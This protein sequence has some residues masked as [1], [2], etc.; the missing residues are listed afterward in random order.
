MKKQILCLLLMGT[1][2]FSPDTLWAQAKIK[3]ACVG[4]SITEGVGVAKG[5]TYP[6]QLQALLGDKYEVRNFG[7]SGRTLL[8]KGDYP[9]WNEARYTEA[10]EWQP[11]MVIIKL[12]TNDS[13]PQNWKWKN[14]FRKDYIA[15]I[16]S[17]KSAANK[18]AIYVCTPIPVFEDRWGITESIVR[19]K[20]IPNAKKAARKTGGKVIDLYTPFIGKKDLTLDGVHPNAEGYTLLAGEVYKGLLP[21]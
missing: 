17:F 3:V 16:N 8:K 2:L 19:N 13:K 7:I 21:R 12:G 10:L 5:K 18:P 14:E 20:I 9:Y 4:N 1:F 6:D 15:F 11:D